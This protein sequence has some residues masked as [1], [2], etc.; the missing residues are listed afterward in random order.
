[1]KLSLALALATSVGYA[2]AL[3]PNSCSGHGE[4]S[5]NDECTCQNSFTGNDCSARECPS[6]TAWVVTSQGDVNSDGDQYDAT[7][8]SDAITASNLPTYFRHYGKGTGIFESWPAVKNDIHK[9]KDEAH[10]PME[11]A[12]QGLC[13]YK[14]G[15]CQCFEGYE[16]V[17]C[18]RSACP[19]SCSNAGVC[20]TISQIG[21]HFL[22]H[23]KATFAANADPATAEP[24]AITTETGPVTYKFWDKD[25]SQACVCDA[26]YG[27]ADCSERQCA[28]GDDPLTLGQHQETQFVDVSADVE[29]SGTLKFEYTDV[30]GA[31]WTT[32]AFATEH[33]D[34]DRTQTA[35]K[36]A[37][38]DALL[39]LPDNML[40]STT[41][42]IGYCETPTDGYHSSSL[43]TCNS[44]IAAA[45]T[46]SQ[47]TFST[48][49]AAPT[50]LANT[51]I[52]VAGQSTVYSIDNAGAATQV[53]GYTCQTTDADDVQLTELASKYCMR[54]E[55]HFGGRSGDVANLGVVT[56]GIIAKTGTVVTETNN[57]AAL[58][59]SAAGVM[60]LTLLATPAAGTALPLTAGISVGEQVHVTHNAISYG[61][62]TVTAVSDTAM[63]LSSTQGA[64]ASTTGVLKLEETAVHTT[65]TKT[66][67]VATTVTDTFDLGT[68]TVSSPLINTACTGL[69]DEA[70]G[71]TG[72]AARCYHGAITAENAATDTAS[73]GN[74][75]TT[76]GVSTLT[77]AASTAIPATG[78][79]AITGG[80]ETVLHYGDEV[81]VFCNGLSL[82]IYTIASTTADTVVFKEVV[83]D[84]NTN[85]YDDATHTTKTAR[86]SHVFLMRTNWVVKTDVDLLVAN[87]DFTGKTVEIDSSTYCDVSSVLADSASATTGSRLVCSNTAAATTAISSAVSVKVYGKG[88]T[89]A[90]TCSDR[91][92]CNTE[93]GSCECFS[94]Y[95]GID[96][97]TQNALKA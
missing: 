75:N 23:T 6:Y 96:C 17:S 86:N 77:C 14:T 85:Y 21:K 69:E 36:D 57:A 53:A 3:C 70:T 34:S 22:T 68:V 16:G 97:S 54:Y 7:T 2:S 18:R 35:L 82:G 20:R 72:Y 91:G 92:L 15:L 52:R 26:G 48:A 80:I 65:L 32:A 59:I 25:M 37:A 4:C 58:E 43:T 38:Q 83:P 74:I 94:G 28:M 1:M 78:T 33:Y 41:V 90:S 61:V 29:F 84:C 24:T 62:A 56:S 47:P 51:Y 73:G 71:C 49:S 93:T 79:T 30:F 50:P 27:G 45:G 44:V 64:L 39:G 13:D 5:A 95:S 63:T 66:N 19:N 12:N 89:E 31:T 81:K 10:Y 8:H 88:T 60:G 67:D 40:A 87:L 46:K 55:V 42:T 76:A 9:D 11:C